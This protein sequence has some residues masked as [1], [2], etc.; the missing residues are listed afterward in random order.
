ML[1]RQGEVRDA[2]HRGLVTGAVAGLVVGVLVGLLI[3]TH[4]P[5]G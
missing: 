1:I 2:Y 3:W 5:W 4:C